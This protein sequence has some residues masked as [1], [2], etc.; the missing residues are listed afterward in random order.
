MLEVGIKR[1]RRKGSHFVPLRKMNK[2]EVKRYFRKE[3][4]VRS[5]AS[6]ARLRSM[7]LNEVRDTRLSGPVPV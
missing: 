5:T 2:E 3:L 1:S 7:L 6:T 4:T